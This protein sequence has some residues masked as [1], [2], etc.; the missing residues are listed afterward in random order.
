MKHGEPTNAEPLSVRIGSLER[1]NMTRDKT[2]TP[3]TPS[4]RR[5]RCLTPCKIK[6]QE[7]SRPS[8]TETISSERRT[9]RPRS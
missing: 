8:K 4:S 6:W 3:R 5:S 1:P 9:R 2:W 7:K